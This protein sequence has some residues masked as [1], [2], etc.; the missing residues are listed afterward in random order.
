MKAATLLLGSIALTGCAA[1]EPARRADSP[2]LP[3]VDIPP[4]PGAPA[5]G[6]A[7]LRAAMLEGH[8]RARA[9]VGVPPLVWDDTLAAHARAYADTLAATGTFRHADQPQGPGREGENLFMGTRYSYSFKEMV[10]LWVAE[11]RFYNGKAVPD[12]SRNGRFGDVAHYTQI[13]WRGSTRVG[14]ALA[15][16]AANDYLVCRYAPAGNVVGSRPY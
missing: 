7:A 15:A 6:D 2:S 9:A 10:D 3:V 16:N 8:N 14:C 11:R 4:F 1:G 13:V 12:S 5:R